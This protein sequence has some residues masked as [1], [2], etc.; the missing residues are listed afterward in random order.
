MTYQRYASTR[1]A[2]L[3]CNL[4]CNAV[5]AARIENRKA[6][7]L[8]VIIH[9]GIFVSQDLG[10]PGASLGFEKLRNWETRNNSMASEVDGWYSMGTLSVVVGLTATAVAGWGSSTIMEAGPFAVDLELVDT[11]V[12][13]TGT[14]VLR[15]FLGLLSRGVPARSRGK[16]ASG[17]ISIMVTPRTGPEQLKPN[18]RHCRQ[19]SPVSSHLMPE[20]ACCNTVMAR[21]PVTRDLAVC[22]RNGAVQRRGV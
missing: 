11:V 7:T 21:L 20:L 16:A 15:I 14:E 8:E 6:G 3:W 4:A 1:A 9:S 17:V 22:Q 19:K 2:E 5:V 10:K 12:F 18:R 13:L